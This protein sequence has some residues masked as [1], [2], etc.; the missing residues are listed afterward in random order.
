[1][2][3]K[4]DTQS[5]SYKATANDNPKDKIEVI[6]GDDKEQDVVLPQE[7]I[8]RWDNESNVSIR[9]LDFEE[10]SVYED[11]GKV[12]FGNETKE[13][14]IY[15][16][17]VSE[18]HPEGGQ[19]FEVILK[20][21]PLTNVVQ[22]S[23]IDKD[24]EYLYQPELEDSE[25]EDL[26]KK[27]NIS[28]LE[29]KR[30]CRPEN[31]V[32]SYAVYAKS[33][34]ANYVG[35]KEYKCGKIGHIYRPKIVDSRGNDIWGELKIDK[36]ILS[37]TVPQ[38]FLDTAVYP[39]I[40]D[41][42]FGYTSAGASGDAELLNSGD[43]R[44]NRYTAP[45]GIGTASN[46][47]AYVRNKWGDSINIKGGIWLQ[48][49]KALVTNAQG[50]ASSSITG[51]SFSQWS[52]TF[53][54]APSLTGGTDYYIGAVGNGGGGSICIAYDSGWTTN[55]GGFSANNYTNFTALDATYFAA[56]SNRYSIYCTYRV[57]VA[58][59]STATTATST[60][61]GDLAISTPAGIQNDDVLILAIATRTSTEYVTGVDDGSGNS[62]TRHGHYSIAGNAN[63]G[64][65]VY[66]KVWS[67]GD[68]TSW[69]IRN[70]NGSSKGLV[71]MM[72][73]Y[74]GVDTTTPIEAT[75]T[76]GG[77]GSSGTS[78]TFAAVT[79]LTDEAWLVG[80]LAG[81]IGSDGWVSENTIGTE[82]ADKSNAGNTPTR[83]SGALF[84][85]FQA[86]AGSSGTKT[87]THTSSVS[88]TIM[89]ALKP[90]SFGGAPAGTNIKINIGDTFKDVSEMKINIGDAWKAVTKV[91]INIGDAWKTVF[92][93]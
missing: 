25:V 48:S 12:I 31:V 47:T 51:T 71:G 13:A 9:L 76:A 88:A 61:S 11:K 38:T 35:G 63:N 20:E 83:L 59:T 27:E 3:Y 5:K 4:P 15:S 28:I 33:N 49:N 64:I 65:A 67:T 21:K 89:F 85:G 42:T 91:Q 55:Y 34:K 62:F 81:L 66:K 56:D 7:K 80:A 77:N 39:V 2:D 1:M 36:G 74:S 53:S 86:A 6:I 44:V 45:T 46:I 72:M 41:P 37:I 24:V 82:R 30:Q 26:A 57:I 52:S 69:T 68:A 75:G 10:Y 19:E 43:C 60:A 40:I 14:H 78:S 50:G 16:L 18:E 23:L 92:G 17:P 8:Q 90:K 93:T 73:A 87:A 32:G 79:T 84:D 29:A 54:T 70:S 22:F 58:R